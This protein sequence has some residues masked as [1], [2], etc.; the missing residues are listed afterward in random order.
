MQP[1]SVTFWFDHACPWTWVTSRW[2]VDVA[3]QRNMS[4][5]WRS[6][7]LSVLNADADVPAEYREPMRASTAAQ[8]VMAAL[9]A[10]DRNDLSGELYRAYGERLFVQKSTITVESVPE[11]AMSVGADAWA[12]AAEDATWDADIEQQTKAAIALAGPDIGSPVISFD[13]V[14]IFGPIVSPAPH[15]AAA[16]ELWDHVVALAT[17]SA[18]F[19]LK[20]GRTQPVNFA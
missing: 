13:D 14:A 9:N 17:N 15:G 11:L 16:I 1:T 3:D 8:R 7:S 18:F 2:L 10:D 20:R 4:I 5:A 12:A 6:L 19:E